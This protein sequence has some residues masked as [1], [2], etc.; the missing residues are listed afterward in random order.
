MRKSERTYKLRATSQI[1]LLLL[2]ASAVTIPLATAQSNGGLAKGAST[3]DFRGF[4]LGMLLGEF[5]KTPPPVETP[6][7][8]DVVP[9][10]D[11]DEP[12]GPTREQA[13]WRAIGVAR[14]EWSE[15]SPLSKF[16][17]TAS[18]H[19]ARFRTDSYRLLFIGKPGDPEPRLFEM[20]FDVRSDAYLELAEALEGRFGKPSKVERTQVQNRLGAVFTNEIRRWTDRHGGVVELLRYTDSLDTTELRFTQSDYLAYFRKRQ[21][22]ESSRLPANL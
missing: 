21:R 13:I 22:E 5:R 20:R 18:I 1:R 17:S 11:I 19:V 15:P 6:L 2:V 7:S 3:F 4:R 10:C 16:G 14:C 9:K 12:L 8:A